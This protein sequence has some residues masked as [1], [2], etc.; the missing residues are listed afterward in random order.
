[1]LKSSS[2]VFAA[3]LTVTALP[4]NAGAADLTTVFQALQGELSGNRARDYVMRIWE[5]DKWSTLPE[6]NKSAAEAEAIMKERGFDETKLDFTPADGIT[7]NGG[8]TNPIGWDAKQATLEVIE[9][10]VPDEFR[11]LCNYRDNPTS[12]NAWSAPTPPG[13]IETELSLIHI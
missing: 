10:S 4:L 13:G 6:W 3:L 5:H 8:W 12:L 11:Y 7:R 1:M 2:V 9:P